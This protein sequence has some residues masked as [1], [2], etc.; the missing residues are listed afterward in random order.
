M[1]WFIQVSLLLILTTLSS[2]SWSSGKGA[3]ASRDIEAD[4]FFQREQMRRKD[5]QNFNQKQVQWQK[6]LDSA[7]KIELEKQKKQQQEYEKVRAEFVKSRKKQRDIFSEDSPEFKADEAAKKRELEK[8]LRIEREYA[9]K[10]KVFQQK[11]EQANLLPEELEF[12][13]TQKQLVPK[14]KR[15]FVLKG[16]SK[17]GSRPSTPSSSF[18]GVPSF[19]SPPSSPSFGGNAGGSGDDFSSGYIPPPPP[20]PPTGIGIEEEDDDFAADAGA[21]PPPSFSDGDSGAVPPPIFDDGDF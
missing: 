3:T 20:P 8:Q 21:I 17:G 7:A 19:S 12:D 15:T 5:F 13:I 11:K 18:G 10:R 6:K 9:A 14:S 4:E 1:S 2:Q 16:A